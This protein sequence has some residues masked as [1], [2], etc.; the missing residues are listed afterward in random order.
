MFR[1]ILLGLFFLAVASVSAV[2]IKNRGLV[3]SWLSPSL[4]KVAAAAVRA[5]AAAQNKQAVFELIQDRF[6]DGGYKTA[7]AFAAPIRDLT[8]LQQLRESVRGRGRRGISEL[9]RLYDKLHFD[10]P[11]TKQQLIEKA[12]V[13]QS[14]GFVFMYEGKFLD[15]S[16][17]FEKSLETSKGP[18]F[19]AAV[20]N[21]LR[22][23]LG[24]VALRRGEIENCLECV[25]PSSCI[26]PIA[27]E[28]VH[29]NQSGSREAVRWFSAYLEESPRD[30]RII[31]LLNIAY[32]TL[33]EYPEK[34]PP[35]YLHSDR[36]CSARGRRG[37]VRERGLAGWADVSRPEPGGRQHL[38][39]LQRRW[40]ARPL[41][42]LA[43]R[44][45]GRLAVRQ[46]RRRHVRG[47]LASAGLGDQVYALNVTRADFDND[48]D[49]DVLLLR[50]GWEIAA[51]AVAPEE[52]RRRDFRGRD[53]RRAAW[54]SRSR[55]SRPPGA[56][57]TTT[58]LSTCSSAASTSRPALRA[59][60]ST[61]PRDPRNRCRLYHNQ[62]DGTF[63]DVAA[64]A[65]VT[66]GRCAKGSGLGR[67]RWRRPARPVRLEHGPAVPA[68]PQRGRRQVPR[69]RTPSSA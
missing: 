8:S 63:S 49:L 5:P 64:E 33:G 41:H 60:S 30:L 1:V 55:R 15:A 50:G 40:P 61:T 9:R 43:R 34:V 45:P 46:S 19:S 35:Q 10:N 23:L 44:R 69:R 37:P 47:P 31:W 52:S 7:M 20:R 16:F 22:A 17:W 53:D 66:N 42:H 4:G 12:S 6:E 51:A 32:M 2:W 54:P 39:R 14:I 11:P 25:G 62:G 28:A 26:F 57:T 18:E 27:R 48:G 21:R 38:R 29:Q 13:E 24:I 36:C 56:I 68:L 65:G 58:A 59:G 3:T 67:L